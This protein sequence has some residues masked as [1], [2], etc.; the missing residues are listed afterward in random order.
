MVLGAGIAPH[1]RSI[2]SQSPDLVSVNG[3][4]G[5]DRPGH[6]LKVGTTDYAC[7]SKYVC[8]R[9]I[10]LSLRSRTWN[11]PFRGR[12]QSIQ[13]P[14]SICSTETALFMNKWRLLEGG[15]SCKLKQ[16]ETEIFSSMAM[17][18]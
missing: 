14:S 7:P 18:Q 13:L 11:T 8:P 1:R 10:V 3:C 4:L 17:T 6:C 15:G 16:S 5:K 12:N 2:R 9:T